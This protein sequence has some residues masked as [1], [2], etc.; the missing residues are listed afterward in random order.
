MEPPQLQSGP[1][2]VAMCQ[3]HA[4]AK[5]YLP[6]RVDSNVPPDHCHL[7]NRGQHVGSGIQDVNR[8]FNRFLSSSSSSSS[9]FPTRVCPSEHVSAHSI[10]G[11]LLQ[12]LCGGMMRFSHSLRWYPRY[13]KLWSFFIF[14]SKSYQTV[15]VH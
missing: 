5:Q 7:E 4:A 12:F 6:R 8:F 11:M 10:F 13:F 14:S 9:Y 3:Q 2:V 1:I 15:L